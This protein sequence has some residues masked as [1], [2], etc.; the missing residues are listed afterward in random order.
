MKQLLDDLCAGLAISMFWI[1]V[2][3]G[4]LWVIIS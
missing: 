4:V 3:S 1:L 2:L